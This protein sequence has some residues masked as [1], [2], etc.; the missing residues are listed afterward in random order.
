M[1]DKYLIIT[2]TNACNLGTDYAMIY[3]IMCKPNTTTLNPVFF[4]F[5]KM[6]SY[7]YA[8]LSIKSYLRFK[9]LNSLLCQLKT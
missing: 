5:V 6:S 4:I 8:S 2:V 9:E 3:Y 1:L 7:I